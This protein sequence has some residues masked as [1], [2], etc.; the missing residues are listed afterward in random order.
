MKNYKANFFLF[1]QTR[2]RVLCA[3]LE[4]A[5]GTFNKRNAIQTAV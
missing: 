5:A 2:L 1:V 3:E 4:F